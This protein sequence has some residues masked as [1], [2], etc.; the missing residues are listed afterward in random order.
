MPC[1]IDTPGT[2]PAED[3]DVGLIARLSAQPWNRTLGAQHTREPRAS[4]SG[5]QLRILEF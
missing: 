4:R 1:Y 3:S 5:V 2:D